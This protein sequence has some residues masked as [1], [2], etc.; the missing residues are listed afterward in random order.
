MRKIKRKTM[1]IVMA[2]L[3]TS[4]ITVVCVGASFWTN[5]E[6]GQ[7]NSS[8]STQ[9]E[10]QSFDVGAESVVS[11]FTADSGVTLTPDV[12]T[13]SYIAEK[14][15]SLLV[16]TI[17]NARL[18]YNN[19]ID[20]SE[21]T[22][23]DLLVEW[24][25]MPKTLG[26]AE[27]TQM[28]VRLE[29][30]EDPRYFVNVS[31]RRYSYNDAALNVTT[32]FLAQPDTVHDYYGWRY[33]EG[34]TT[35]LQLGTM[36]RSC[37]VG[38]KSKDGKTYSN[39]MKLYYD[40]EERALYTSLGPG[41]TS[42][43][44]TDGD[45]KLVI[46]DM[47]DP[48]YM[49]ASTAKHWKGFPSNK[50]KISFTA[51]MV[52]EN[53][54]QY[55]IYSIDGQSFEGKLLNDTTPPKLTVNNQGYIASEMPIGK[56]NAFYPFFKA[57]AVDKISG[58]LPV[59]VRVTKNGEEFYHAGKG[60]V[61]TATGDYNI[62]YSATD[63][64]GNQSK[65]THTVT[66]ENS[67]NAMQCE[68]QQT[69]G[70]LVLA[71]GVNNAISLY[72]PV[73]LPEML[74]EGGSGKPSVEVFVTYNGNEVKVT[75]NTFA[76]QNKGVYAV[77]YVAT[78]YIGNTVGKTYTLEATY[79]DIPQLIEP[80]LPT[81]VLLDKAVE[82]P[83]VNSLYYAVWGQKVTA[84]DTITVYK[85]DKTT[86]IKEF[87][88]SQPAIY[89][90]TETDGEKVYVEYATA[91][92]K[93]A[94]AR[95]YGQEISL[96]KSTKLA[97]RFLFGDGITMTE[98]DL[99]LSFTSTQEGASVRYINPLSVYD[100][101]SLEFNVPKQANGYNEV[102]VTFTDAEDKNISLTV[103]VYKNS[104][105]KATKSD[106]AI[107]GDRSTNSQ[108]SASFY[109]N[110]ITKFLFTLSQNG[111]VTHS[112]LGLEKPSADFKG[113]SSG[114]V[115]MD[116][117]LHGLEQQKPATV[118]IY[119]V[120]NQITGNDSE[121]YTKPIMYIE[122]EPIGITTL[123]SWVEIPAARASD[124]FDVQVTL[125]VKVT[126]GNKTVYTAE[127]A[128]GK[129]DG[130][131]IAATDYGTYI[132]TY[133]A[134]DASFNTTKKKYTIRVRD[135]VAPVITVDGDMPETVTAG[136]KLTFPSVSASDNVDAELTLYAIIIDPMNRFATI[137]LNEEY[138]PTEKGR[139]I[140]CFYCADSCANQTYSQDYY[141]TVV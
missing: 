84:Y 121:D 16:E 115:Y 127:S 81:V 22:K 53:S 129:L 29:D 9:M 126:F 61:P 5:A 23:E 85:A 103:S 27:M 47:D 52:E 140:V 7:E 73:K 65:T 20:V 106:I 119:R 26:V 79:S 96:Q 78:D 133:E 67:V 116:I 82:L 55:M 139:Y 97:D 13:P 33:G 80:I 64:Y 48:M 131:K 100:T 54:A 42:V 28:I 11:Y 70:S 69:A 46:V 123:G 122:N 71:D 31:M 137:K 83:K 51:T 59:Q 21:M 141:F 35:D 128:F 45:G 98:E 75:D 86:V 15:N 58:E 113:F 90:P 39:G 138:V 132:I 57:T 12:D 101:L 6:Q 19:V 130:A 49:G 109:G 107:N 108:I 63:R 110:V 1:R 38:Q 24:Q 95:K 89:T 102:R 99:S 135:N 72:Y 91:K 114:Y 74:V 124:V 88:G 118:M 37:W 56:V 41:V 77:T 4:A 34:I 104:D 68:L 93:G 105:E 14:R 125:T 30:A 8:V 94:T 3:I 17:Q 43:Y 76:P 136:E 117:S 92:A 44:D 40:N 120:K 62:E 10:T 36:V 2:T 32:H 87:D 60:F 50:I 18:T 134:C 25:P 112:E 66:V 111:N